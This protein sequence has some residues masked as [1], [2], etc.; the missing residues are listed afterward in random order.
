MNQSGFTLVELMVVVVIIVIVSSFA[1][2]AYQSYVETSQEG[3]LRSSLM[4][5]EVFQEDY[6]LRRG[7]YANNLANVAAIEGE[8]GW[9][10]R[11]DD[12]TTY[13]I[14]NSDGTFYQMTA[15]HPD[16]MTICMRFPDRDPCV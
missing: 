11:N 9:A 10:P 15:V 5:V 8:I 1:V 13:S 7:F 2:P 4:T 6:F 14:A 12:G 3:T 16:G